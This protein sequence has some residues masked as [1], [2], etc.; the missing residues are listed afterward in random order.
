M[1]RNSPELADFNRALTS[2]RIYRRS[3]LDKVQELIKKD[4]ALHNRIIHIDWGIAGDIE[5][6]CEHLTK[7]VQLLENERTF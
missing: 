6:Q 7:V 4:E 2:S 5:R 3:L 1:P